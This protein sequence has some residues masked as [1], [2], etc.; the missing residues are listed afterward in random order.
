MRGFSVA[1]SASF[2]TADVPSAFSSST[3]RLHIHQGLS[4]IGLVAN[5]LREC[6][7]DLHPAVVWRHRPASPRRRFALLMTATTSF[8]HVVVQQA[9]LF[10]AAGCTAKI[11]VGGPHVTYFG[12]QV[13]AP[14]FDY[15][16]I[17][18]ADNS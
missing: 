16:A 5:R 7:A 13:F 10:K 2:C 17:G 6:R 1:A 4:P 12:E 15:V 3:V 18:H 9:E 11:V 14:A 8:F